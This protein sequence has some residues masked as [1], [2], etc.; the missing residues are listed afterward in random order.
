[1]GLNPRSS[2]SVS[3]RGEGFA[4]SDPRRTVVWVRGEHD[5]ATAQLD[6]ETMTRAVMLDDADVV[7]DLSGVEFMDASTVGTIVRTRNL[8]GSRSRSLTLRSPST[9]A[10]RVLHACHLA[11]LVEPDGFDERSAVALATWVAVPA[12]GRDPHAASDGPER[13]VTHDRVP[14]VAAAPGSAL[15]ARPLRAEPLHENG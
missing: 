7:V 6:A 2:V 10:Q 9:C 1:M 5:M 12:T 11:A 13:A 14:V 4:R 15:G 8:L 3:P